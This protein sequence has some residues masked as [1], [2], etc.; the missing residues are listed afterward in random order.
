MENLIFFLTLTL[1]GCGNSMADYNEAL[2]KNIFDSA[3]DSII[4][5]KIIA[6]FQGSLEFGDRALGNRSILADP[7][8]SDMKDQINKKINLLQDHCPSAF[9]RSIY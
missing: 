6:W 9:I 4:E 1:V 2:I 3:S 5:G 8:I 7:G